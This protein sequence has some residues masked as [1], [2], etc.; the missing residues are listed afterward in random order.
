M[1]VQS[2]TFVGWRA[3]VCELSGYVSGNLAH[4]IIRWSVRV[5]MIFI[6]CLAWPPTEAGANEI[7]RAESRYLFQPMPDS[8]FTAPDGQ[9][10]R[11]SAIWEKGPAL[12][13][14]FYARC[15]GSDGRL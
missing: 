2:R 3:F 14:R 5:C 12:S 8:E 15:T 11:L 10:N 13:N 9:K 1:L 4:A 7:L 6:A